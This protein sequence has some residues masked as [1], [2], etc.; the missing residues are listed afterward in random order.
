MDLSL[1][2][3]TD[4]YEELLNRFD[5]AIFV[6]KKIGE[7]DSSISRRYKGDHHLAMG[8]CNDLIHEINRE[9]IQSENLIT[10]EDL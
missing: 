3:I 6:G 9:I 2:P 10:P 7:K 1:V 4:L 5:V 8:L